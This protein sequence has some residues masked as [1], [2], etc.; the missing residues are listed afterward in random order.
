MCT[1]DICFDITQNKF[2]FY[3]IKTNTTSNTFKI[4]YSSLKTIANHEKEKTPFNMYHFGTVDTF[5]F[6]KTTILDREKNSFKQNISD[7]IILT[8]IV[9]I[10]LFYPKP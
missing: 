3:S 9:N 4:E 6:D 1:K 5:I 10:K 2:A 8:L 7:M